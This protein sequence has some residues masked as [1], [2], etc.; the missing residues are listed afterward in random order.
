MVLSGKTPLAKPR[1]KASP[2]MALNC[3]GLTVP[4]VLA[5]I[6]RFPMSACQDEA[7]RQGKTSDF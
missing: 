5:A 7:A 2:F 3:S 4:K 6:F 1:T